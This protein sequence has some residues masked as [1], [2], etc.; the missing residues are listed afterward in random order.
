MSPDSPCAVE[1]ENVE[2]GPG[3]PSTDEPL[4]T[5]LSTANLKL[6]AAK[7]HLYSM[8]KLLTP[9]GP[10]L[11][12]SKRWLRSLLGSN[13][14][15]HFVRIELPST[16][17]LTNSILEGFPRIHWL[18]WLCRDWW[19]ERGYRLLYFVCDLSHGPV[20]RITGGRCPLTSCTG[21]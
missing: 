12:I 5:A 11:E 8:R 10:L 3:G 19:N 14:C 16:T 6:M 2:E 21:P 4:H 9:P 20:E 7:D 17:S 15:N 18:T 13:E 1:K